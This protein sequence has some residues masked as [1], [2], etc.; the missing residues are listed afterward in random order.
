[1]PIITA[2]PIDTLNKIVAL[3]FPITHYIINNYIKS[4]TISFDKYNRKKQLKRQER[5]SPSGD[6]GKQFYI[7]QRYSK[8]S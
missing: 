7:L 8:I 4:S 3:P 1:M 2:I 5:R 6:F